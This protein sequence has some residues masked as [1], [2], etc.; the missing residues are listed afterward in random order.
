MEWVAQSGSGSSGGSGTPDAKKAK[1]K[2]KDK[3]GKGGGGS[4]ELPPHYKAIA[5]QLCRVSRDVE[6]LKA[7]T[8]LS[9]KSPASNSIVQAGLGAGKNYSKMVKDVKDHGKGKPHCHVFGAMVN[10]LLAELA[11]G[12]SGPRAAELQ[13]SHETVKNFCAMIKKP[14]DLEEKVLHCVLR[15]QYKKEFVKVEWHVTSHTTILSEILMGALKYAGSEQ[16]LGAGPKNPA[17]RKLGNFLAKK[18]TEEEED[19]EED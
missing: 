6:A 17:E 18:K 12:L 14:Q 8:F 13:G 10:A 1:T 3:K 16:Y 15:L 7:C 19:D 5:A 11:A 9:C 4:G 2:N